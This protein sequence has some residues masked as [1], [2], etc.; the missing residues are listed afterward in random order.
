MSERAHALTPSASACE[1]EGR[2]PS[3]ESIVCEEELY[4]SLH[5]IGV[6]IAAYHFGRATNDSR[7]KRVRLVQWRHLLVP[8]VQ[9]LFGGTV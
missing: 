1:P 6:R 9:F 4:S 5:P 7:L 3:R 8:W 2:R